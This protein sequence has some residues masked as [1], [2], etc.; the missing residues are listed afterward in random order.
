LRIIKDTFF[1]CKIR[2]SI[3]SGRKG[4]KNFRFQPQ[5]E[6]DS[7][8]IRVFLNPLLA[9]LLCSYAA[10]PRPDS[11][12]LVNEYFYFQIRS[13]IVCSIDPVGSPRVVTGGMRHAPPSTWTR[14]RGRQQNN[15]RAR[16]ASQLAVSFV[17]PFCSSY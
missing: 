15:E 16:N 8:R 3:D 9:S 12:G 13:K 2:S 1:R 14:K 5:G 6:D 4:T 7:I 17:V 10:P 11:F